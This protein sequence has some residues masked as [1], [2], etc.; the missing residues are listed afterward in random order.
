MKT[1]LFIGLVLMI[2]HTTQASESVDSESLNFT[3]E[4]NER[5]PQILQPFFKT[6]MRGTL[7][8]M[9]Q[10]TQLKG[11]TETCVAAA[12]ACIAACWYCAGCCAPACY[13]AER[14]CED[15]CKR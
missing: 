8:K 9:P 5:I 6:Y 4:Q 7:S 12:A 15:Q 13:A 14:A 1:L 2:L 3:P 11:C 10:L